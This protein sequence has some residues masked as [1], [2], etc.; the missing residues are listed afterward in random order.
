MGLVEKVL[1]KYPYLA[2]KR[3]GPHIVKKLNSKFVYEYSIEDGEYYGLN[4]TDRIGLLLIIGA[5]IPN[6]D[7]ITT[8]F[9]KY[10]GAREYGHHYTLDQNQVL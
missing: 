9:L 10:V 6:F 8:D 7:G 2:V 5:S 1:A 3:N 4:D